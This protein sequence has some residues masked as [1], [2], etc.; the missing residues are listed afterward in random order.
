LGRI[1]LDLVAEEFERLDL[2]NR[3]C[4]D[5]LVKIIVALSHVKRGR[6]FEHTLTQ[7]TDGVG[8]AQWGVPF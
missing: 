4:F 5:H 6:I 2:A 1:T 7:R 3:N 8:L